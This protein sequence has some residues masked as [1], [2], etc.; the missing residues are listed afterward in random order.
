[1]FSPSGKKTAEDSSRDRRYHYL[2][3]GQQG[4]YPFGQTGNLARSILFVD[5][6]FHRC[7]LNNRDR[8]LQRFLGLIPGFQLNGLKDLLYNTLH[9][10]LVGAI[11]KPLQ[12]VLTIPFLG[13]FM[14]SQ[15]STPVCCI[16]D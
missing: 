12:L 1:V 9:L 5:G 4:I 14:I 16:V 6:T 2:H 15:F 13:G 10:G 3:G 8:H 7:F 11:A